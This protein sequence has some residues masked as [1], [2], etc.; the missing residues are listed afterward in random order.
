MSIVP[1]IISGSS[2]YGVAAYNKKVDDGTAKVLWYPKITTGTFGNVTIENCVQTFEPYIA[3]NS[4]VRKPVQGNVRLQKPALSR[5]AARSHKPQ[6]H[7][8]GTHQREEGKDRPQP[9]G[10]SGTES[11]LYSVQQVACLLS[12]VSH[13]PANSLQQKRLTFQYYSLGIIYKQ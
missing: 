8:I 7:C 1:N 4:H 13:Y 6:A 9:R 10:Y 12:R 11:Q 3:V 2:S 5:I